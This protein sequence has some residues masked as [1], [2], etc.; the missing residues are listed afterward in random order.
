VADL[1]W[2]C[3][4]ANPSVKLYGFRVY[5]NGKQYGADL[6]ES[7]RSIRVSLS[8]EKP[9]YTI[10]VTA[11]TDRPKLESQLSNV[12]H[13]SGEQ[14]L[15][16]TYYCYHDVH[17]KNTSYFFFKYILELSH[18]VSFLNNYLNNSKTFF[19]NAYL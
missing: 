1:R 11:Y 19:S 15:P 18:F 17:C 16:F 3:N 9:I 4:Q 2:T 8:L 5:I 10:H 14:Y 6:D 12:V 13:L 7:I